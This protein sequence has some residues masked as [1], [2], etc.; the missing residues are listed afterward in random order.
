MS[1]HDQRDDYDDKTRISDQLQDKELDHSLSQ[2]W[3]VGFTQLLIAQFAVV[4]IL[5]LMIVFG[6]GLN[7]RG[8][9][10]VELLIPFLVWI[11]GTAFNIVVILGATV[12]SRA[13]MYWL[14]LLA[15]LIAMTSFPAVWF[16]PV[17]SYLALRALR[18][19][20]N[21]D[22]RA[23]FEAVARGTITSHSSEVTDAR[24]DRST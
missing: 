22:V 10:A 1:E 4:V 11:I 17:T 5:M 14:A 2:L 16:A 7:D 23:R 21:R 13:K 18:R 15:S 12:G 6:D 9:I 3:W 19:L 20:A 8:S 24:S